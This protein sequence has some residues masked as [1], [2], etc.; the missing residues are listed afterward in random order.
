MKILKFS[1]P[2]LIILLSTCIQ[3][4]VEH[5][6]LSKQEKSEGWSLLF[7][8]K[9]MDQWRVYHRDSISGWVV[10]D[11]T[12]KAQ[13]LGDEFSG[14]IITRDQFENF[15][16]S[17]E[18]KLS[19]GGNSGILYLVH[20]DPAYA[21]IAETG[22]EYQIIDDLGWFE[23]LEDWQLTAANY[24]MHIA[25]NKVLNPIGEWNTARIIKDGTKVEH[26]LNGIMVVDYELWTE[27]WKSRVA[28]GKWKDYPGYGQF[29]KG[30][31]ALQDHGAAI[32]FRNI[33]IRQTP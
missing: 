32:W 25:K 7:D 33:K 3:A 18:W 30:H 23:P 8:G 10:E 31:I 15:E 20:E 13:G 24:A 11:G 6:T 2:V 4:P 12:L 27:D 14:D 5:N 26:W 19:P 21:G 22:P 1:L 29:K 16:L 28:S 17:L 9:S